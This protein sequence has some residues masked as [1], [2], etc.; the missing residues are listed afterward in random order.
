MNPCGCNLADCMICNEWNDEQWERYEEDGPMDLE[1]QLEV[2][3]NLFSRF[4]ADD[5]Q[6]HICGRKTGQAHMTTCKTPG[7][8]VKRPCSPAQRD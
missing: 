3:L 8:I 7:L 6:C 2:S 4:N 5:Y 1:D